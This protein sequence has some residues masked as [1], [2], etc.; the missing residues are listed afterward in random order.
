MHQ[1]CDAK[2][3]ELRGDIDKSTKII[4]EF[5]ILLSIID[6]TTKQISKDREF[7]NTINQQDLIDF[8]RTIYLARASTEP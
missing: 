2:L 1:T 8:C 5:N 7:D 4:G 6:R 3:I